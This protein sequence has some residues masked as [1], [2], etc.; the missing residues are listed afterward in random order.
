[1]VFDDLL[2]FHRSTWG[3]LVPLVWGFSSR[4]LP[5]FM[6]LRPLR[7]P[8][9]LVGLGLNTSGVVAGFF[10]RF[11]AAGIL[12]LAGAATAIAAIHLFEPGAKPGKTINVHRSFPIF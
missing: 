4:W 7:N 6:G 10:E 12:L 3:F 9:L 8:L 5:V 1:M 2:G 11:T